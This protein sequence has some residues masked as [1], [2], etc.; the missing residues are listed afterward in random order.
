MHDLVIAGGLVA[1]GGELRPADIG[2]SAG[3]IAQLGTGLSGRDTIHAAGKWVMPG[4]IDSHCHLDQ[5]VWGSA[6]SADDFVSGSIS[7]AFGGLTC[8]IPFGMPGPGMSTLEAFDRAA[9]RAEGKSVI[10]YSL[11]GV[12][13][14]ASPSNVRAQLERLIGDGVGSVKVFMTYGELFVGDDLFLEVLDVSR[15]LGLLVMVHAE[16]DA[17]I[18]YMTD[19]LLKS[20]RTALRYHT[21]SRSEVIEREATHRA[22]ALAELTGARMAI[23]HVS[24]APALEEIVRAR[25][26]GVDV[27]GE[28]CP[29]Y[30]FLSAADLDQE[31]EKAARY[32]FSPP[33]RSRT[34]H[35]PLWAALRYGDLD[36]WSS[37]HSP[38]A[39]V[40]K[41]PDPAEPRFD[42]AVN[43]IPGL[44]TQLPLLFSEMRA[45]RLTL[46][47]FLDLSAGNAAKLY[48]LA[49]IKGR[50]EVGLHAD[51]TL[52][53]PDEHWTLAQSILHSKV[54]FTPFEGMAVTGRPKTVLVRG[55][56]VIRDGAL[57]AQ[58]GHGVFTK[59]A[60]MKPR[61]RAILADD[62]QPWLD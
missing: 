53:D 1:L 51:L 12:V 29:Q 46:Q 50:I 27:T 37:D 23:L 45:G 30:L 42:R 22:A 7:A 31:P 62:T 39:S 57:A 36:L 61:P 9:G 6:A 40:D 17:G 56:P 3:L 20:G 19:R 18:R 34:N 47:R 24:C 11:H 38:Y 43:G 35:E 5:P 32:I 15:D 26:R 58:P 25:A 44:E 55:M 60:T 59:C 4:G 14:G 48:G 41:L 49:H 13:T 54:D 10:D 28:T 16:N 52:W 2:I 21:L 33:T 8:I